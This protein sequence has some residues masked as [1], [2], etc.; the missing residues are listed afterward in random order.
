LRTKQPWCPDAGENKIEIGVSETKAEEKEG[1]FDQ[2]ARQ[3]GDK[4]A[5]C[6]VIAFVIVLAQDRL[7]G[8]LDVTVHLVDDSI[9]P[10]TRRG[11]LFVCVL[12]IDASSSSFKSLFDQPIVI[13]RP[14]CSD[15]QSS[16]KRVIFRR[17]FQVGKLIDQ[18]LIEVM[19]VGSICV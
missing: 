14:V 7:V 13:G 1:L 11:E 8:M 15:W 9:A 3:G 19:P 18:K 12:R 5:M 4:W 2:V 16:Q 6:I 10:T 17:V